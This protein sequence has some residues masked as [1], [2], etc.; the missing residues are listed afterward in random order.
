MS[1]LSLRSSL[2]SIPGQ[3]LPRLQAARVLGY[4]SRLDRTRLLRRTPHHVQAN[5]DH[6]RP[7]KHMERYQL[8]HL[9]HWALHHWALHQ[10]QLHQGPLQ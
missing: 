9:L 1:P 10:W 6:R 2:G 8:W 4:I 3:G 7:G 5:Q